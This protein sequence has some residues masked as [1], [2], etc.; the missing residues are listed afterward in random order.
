MDVPHR[1]AEPLL[2]VLPRIAVEE[3]LILVDG[4]RDDVEVEPLRRF[5]LAVHEERQRSGLA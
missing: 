4:A 1:I 2:P 5:G 3:L